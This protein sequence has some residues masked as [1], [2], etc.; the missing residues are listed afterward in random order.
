MSQGLWEWLPDSMTAMV[1][2][3]LG[4]GEARIQSTWAAY[5]WKSCGLLDSIRL[6]F[7]PL[8]SLRAS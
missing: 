3:G 7:F 4:G 1:E 2:E 6:L 8:V 5:T